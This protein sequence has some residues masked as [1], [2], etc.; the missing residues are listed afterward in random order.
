MCNFGTSWGLSQEKA[1]GVLKIEETASSLKKHSSLVASEKLPHSIAWEC[2]LCN[3]CI[4]P[5]NLFETD[6]TFVLPLGKHVR[7]LRSEIWE[8]WVA[9]NDFNEVKHHLHLQRIFCDDNNRWTV[10]ALFIIPFHAFV[11]GFFLKSIVSKSARNPF[12]CIFFIIR[13]F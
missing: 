5:M 4:V 1:F 12:S 3:W 10:S 9:I 13:N 6:L 2:L 11:C 8:S 7:I